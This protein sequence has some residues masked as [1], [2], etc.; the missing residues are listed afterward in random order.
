MIYISHLTLS[1]IQF[2]SLIDE[3]KKIKIR[4]IRISNIDFDFLK[5]H[6]DLI[7]KLE[8]IS[9]CYDLLIMLKSKSIFNKDNMFLT[10]S[11]KNKMIDEVSGDPFYS[12]SLALNYFNRPWHEVKEVD[13]KIIDKAHLSISSDSYEAYNYARD[14]L[15]NAWSDQI[16]IGKKLVLDTEL[17]ISKSSY[18]TD[19]AIHVLRKPW[20]KTFLSPKQ[21]FETE[22]KVLESLENLDESYGINKIISYINLY[23]TNEKEYNFINDNNIS[24]EFK[25]LILKSFFYHDG[26]LQ[27]F[28][29]RVLRNNWRKYKNIIEDISNDPKIIDKIE[30]YFASEPSNAQY[31]AINFLKSPW[32]KYT[33]LNEKIDPETARMA[34]ANIASVDSLANV[35]AKLILK[36]PWHEEK[37]IDPEIRELAENNILTSPEISLEYARDVI[38]GRWEKAEPII[39][40]KL[41]IYEKYKKEVLKK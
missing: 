7:L 36:K 2:E 25:N 13:K 6:K 18:S 14:V 30:R 38:E 23:K 31:Y 29:S 28:T 17:N 40:S 26:F 34:N 22:S 20:N 3:I 5:K 27:I 15:G 24:K 39:M 37:E 1:K 4:V 41:D 32:H 35:Y 9:L 12:Y 10:E 11:E 19:Y 8:C 33:Y 21:T 16:E